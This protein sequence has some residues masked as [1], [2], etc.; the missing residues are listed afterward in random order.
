LNAYLVSSNKVFTYETTID[1][2]RQFFVAHLVDGLPEDY[3]EQISDELTD[4]NILDSIEAHAPGTYE[5]GGTIDLILI[6]R[7][8]SGVPVPIGKC[9]DLSL[10]DSNENPLSTAYLLTPNHIC[11]DGDQFEVMI[12][13]DAAIPLSSVNLLL[14]EA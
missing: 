5:D 2:N 10:V 4:A 8:K 11:A 12:S 9:F 6:G 3:E 13:V 7:D 14:I 1:I